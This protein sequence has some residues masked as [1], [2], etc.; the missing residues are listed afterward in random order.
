MPI[1]NFVQCEIRKSTIWITIVCLFLIKSSSISG[2]TAPA[3]RRNTAITRQSNA[4]SQAYLN[5]IR[6][7]LLKN[8]ELIDGK[9][10]VILQGIVDLDGSLSE[11]KSISASE[12]SA[13]AIDSA[14]N[15]VEKCKPF[16]AL[17]GSYKHS[18]KLTLTFH[19]TV[20]P[21][22]D[23]DSSISTEMTELQ[24]TS[25]PSNLK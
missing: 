12:T 4:A 25:S 22:G 13:L 15:A 9:N 2:I 3:I 1:K 18:C 8:W 14:M 24:S 21:H 5:N 23:S 17:P 10:T 11:V 16:P 20:D 7:G 19:S 6:Q